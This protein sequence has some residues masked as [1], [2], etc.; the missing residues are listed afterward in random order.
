MAEVAREFFIAEDSHYLWVRDEQ[1]FM[2]VPSS[3]GDQPLSANERQELMRLRREM[4][5]LQKD[6]AFLG[7]PTA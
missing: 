5:E 7:M 3:T 1:R 2:E 4:A 6:N